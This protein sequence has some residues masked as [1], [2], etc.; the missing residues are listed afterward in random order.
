MWNL[1]IKSPAKRQSS[2]SKL[3]PLTYSKHVGRLLIGLKQAGKTLAIRPL[4]C[5]AILTIASC[6]NLGCRT[7]PGTLTIVLSFWQWPR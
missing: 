6:A 5:T 4:G 2:G 1:K 7:I 3:P